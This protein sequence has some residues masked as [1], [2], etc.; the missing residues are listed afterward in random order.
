MPDNALVRLIYEATF[1]SIRATV[2]EGGVSDR[3]LYAR[4]ERAV[5]QNARR[6]SATAKQL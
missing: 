1:L 2:G 6:I 3:R 5:M 4:R